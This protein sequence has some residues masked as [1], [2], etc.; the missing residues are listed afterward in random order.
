MEETTYSSTFAD[1]R[2]ATFS[3]RP[4]PRELDHLFVN[5]VRFWSMLSIIAVHSWY[6][7]GTARSSFD[8]VAVTPFK[9][10]T[11]GFFLIAGFLLGERVDRR[12]PVEYFMRRVSRVFVPWALWF[13][14]FC[15]GLLIYHLADPVLRHSNATEL[16][17]MLLTTSRAALYDTSFWF[18]PNLLVCM[19]VL[20]ICRRYIYTLKL[21]FVLLAVNLVYV[22]NIYMQWFQSDHPRALFGFVFYLWLGSY[23]A[24]KFK[25]ISAVLDKI[26]TPV[27]VAMTVLSGIASYGESH[28]LAVT[29]HSDALNTLRLSN[30][31]FSVSIVLAIFKF[32]Q[33]TWPQF[34]DVRRDTFG[35]YLTHTPVLRCLLHLMKHVTR[36]TSIFTREAEGVAFW[37][38]VS[39]TTY[40]CG[41]IITHFLAKRKSTE[42]MVGVRSGDSQ[43][44]FSG[45]ELS[46]V[47]AH[48]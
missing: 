43:R 11:I 13:G 18:V 42:W 29:N 47:A 32:S 33:A 31:I 28:L 10:A 21:G 20:L 22:V 5:N 16:L 30:Q 25:R 26:Q 3:G 2:V 34:V 7:F 39:V 14:V 1:R 23:A 40:S 35:L 36:S 17:E 24:H 45:S 4:R 41:L 6:V 8:I 38:A 48:G 15:A 46:A 44:S 27:I 9:F 37:I 19:A 12:N